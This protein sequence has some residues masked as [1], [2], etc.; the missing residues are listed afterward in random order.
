MLQPPPPQ[1][2]TNDEAEVDKVVRV[3]GEEGCDREQEMQGKGPILLFLPG[4]IIHIIA[5]DTTNTR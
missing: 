2:D 3:E 5:S 1:E 4:R